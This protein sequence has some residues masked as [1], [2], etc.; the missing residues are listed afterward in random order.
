MEGDVDR[1][2]R[3]LIVDDDRETRETLREVFDELGHG[4]LC[5]TDGAEALE[6]LRREHDI[7]FVLLD[8]LMP[9]MDGYEFRR[10]QLADRELSRVPVVVFSGDGEAC[11]RLAAAPPVAVLTKPI[12]FTD[13][14]AA[15]ELGDHAER[16]MMAARDR[17]RSRI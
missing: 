8:L 12:K 10:H 4:A 11:E 6:L 9:G 7:D 3:V 13:L 14:L 15:L 5:A 16:E 2:M 17:E 1:R